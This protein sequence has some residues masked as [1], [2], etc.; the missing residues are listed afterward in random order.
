MSL[1]TA[2][3][4]YLN[5]LEQILEL[6]DEAKQAAQT[7]TTEPRGSL[8]V[9][10]PV[11]MG[12]LHIAPMVS[13]FLRKYPQVSLDLQ[14]TDRQADL[15]TAGIDIAIR[16]G[17]LPDSS[18][19]AT[20]LATTRRVLCASPAYL[21]KHGTPEIP[22]DL[23]R[24]NCLITTLYTIRNI[25]HFRRGAEHRSVDVRGTFKSNNSEALR[26]AAIGGLG[27]GLLSTWSVFPH[28]SAG[29]LV[30]VLPEWQGELTTTPRN[31]YAIYPRTTYP[32]PAISAFV[33]YL[34]DY[35]GSPP[36]WDK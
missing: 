20:K 3:R 17:E 4:D 10:C 8:T 24:H 25:W 19:I 23:A 15:G 36:F 31:T 14:L 6:I 30:S 32:A 33:E 35:W 26:D 12:R 29:K 11:T 7:H 28:L 2:G 13:K 34:R 9:S 21:S 27:F 16:I 18:L 22:E 5:R 1:T